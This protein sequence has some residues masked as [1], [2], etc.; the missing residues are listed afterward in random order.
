MNGWDLFTWFNSALLGGIAVAI[1]VLFL[2]DAGGILSGP[3]RESDSERDDAQSE[4]NPDQ[5]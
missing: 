2:R 5:S 1:F 3:G 4:V